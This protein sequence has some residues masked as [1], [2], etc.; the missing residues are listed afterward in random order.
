MQ[1]NFFIKREDSTYIGIVLEVLGVEKPEG[2]TSL[3]VDLLIDG[4]LPVRVSQNK[5]QWIIS[6][7]IAREGSRSEEEALGK[8]IERANELWGKLV[9][10]ISYEKR[11][12]ILILWKDITEYKSKEELEPMMNRFLEELEYW[13]MEAANAGCTGK[14]IFP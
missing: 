7:T 8:I 2:R 12:D 13:R 10:T 4:Q 3:P 14:D 5:K 1:P 11:E 6:G 9:G